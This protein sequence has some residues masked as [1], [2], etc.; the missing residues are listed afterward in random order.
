[1]I[2]GG[3]YPYINKEQI[4]LINTDIII[5]MAEGNVFRE[6]YVEALAIG[7]SDE[8][9]IPINILK[10]PGFD[11]DKYINIKKNPPS[12][13]AN[14]C[15]GGL[16]YHSL[17]LKFM[18][19]LINMFENIPD[20]L[21]LLSKPV[22]YM[23]RNLELFEMG[24]DNTLKK[25]YPIVKCNDILL[26]FNHYFSFDEARE[27]W[28]KR[29]KRINWENIFVMMYTEREDYAEEFAKLPY[30]KKVCFVPYNSDENCL[31]SKRRV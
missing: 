21:K 8:N 24:Y 16:T 27:C 18:S 3:G 28:E 23:D 30:T 22:A 31:I 4:K 13:F 6:I 5:I 7:V 29:K 10:Y 2:H 26:H 17:G 19:P 14:N 20:Y 15:W 1:M 25:E 12:L 9:I 11:I